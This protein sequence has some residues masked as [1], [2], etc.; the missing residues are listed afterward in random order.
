MSKADEL[1]VMDFLCH[2]LDAIQRI[3]RYIGT[4]YIDFGF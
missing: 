1:R 3:N 4:L 2:I